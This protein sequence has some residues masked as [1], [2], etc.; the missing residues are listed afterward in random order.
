[1]IE[2]SSPIVSHLLRY[3]YDEQWPQKRHVVLIRK[4]ASRRA[5]RKVVVS[6]GATVVDATLRAA[7]LMERSVMYVASYYSR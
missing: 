7:I 3:L 6:T 1:M 2:T 4:V 5:H